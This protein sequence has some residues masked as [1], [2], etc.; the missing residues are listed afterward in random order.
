[1]GFKF[2]VYLSVPISGEAYISFITPDHPPLEEW[3]EVTAILSRLISNRVIVGNLQGV[4]R[5]CS[6]VNSKPV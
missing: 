5:A 3:Q 6:V 1:L 4:D 2:P